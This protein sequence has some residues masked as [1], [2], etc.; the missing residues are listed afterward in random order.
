MKLKLSL[1]TKILM[2]AIIP[3]SCLFAFFMYISFSNGSR[4]LLLEKENAITDVTTTVIKYLE[5]MDNKVTKGILTK[6]EAQNHA[7]DYIKSIRYGR[8]N[9]DY[10]WVNDLTPFMIV[11]P[12][13][14]LEGTSLDKFQDKK[15][16]FLF[17]DVVNLV[18]KEEKGFV[19][20]TWI[21]KKDQNKFVEK[22]SYVQLYKP[23]GWVV[24]TGI[25]TEDVNEYILKEFVNQIIVGGLGIILITCLFIIILKK[26]VSN[27]LIAMANKLRT[28]SSNVERGSFETSNTSD[29]LSK[30]TQEQASSLQQTVSSVDEI[31]SMIDRNNDFASQSKNTSEQSKEYVIHGKK[32]VDE[33]VMAIEEIGNHNGETMEKMEKSNHRI[34]EILD[35]IKNIE[36]KTKVI[37]DIVFQTKLLSFNASVEAA[38]AGESGK[39]FAVVAEEVGNLATMSGKASNEIKSLIDQSIKS[40]ETIVQDTS[41]MIKDVVNQGA[42]TVDAGKLKA[43]ECKNI[44]DEFVIN[45]QDVNTKITEISLACHEQSQGVSEITK[46]MQ[47]LDDVTHQN[48]NAAQIAARNAGE[49]QREVST[50]NSVIDDV[51]KLV[52]G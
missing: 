10:L 42:K 51:L 28:S 12:S 47:M 40:V 15:G 4:A 46:A 50:L 41:S 38:R 21:S 31:S 25:Y 39:G 45:V 43:Q 14:K 26:G 19:N 36:D 7:K 3:F 37:N 48:N 24:G 11:H 5:V 1:N 34:A 52:A 16:K 49:L 29:I 17:V 8:D 22:L 9:D 18:K 33:M 23:W 44:L 6:E 20:Y 13:A 27:P 30:A 35:I 32:T 2:M